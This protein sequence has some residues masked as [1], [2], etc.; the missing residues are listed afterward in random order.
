MLAMPTCTPAD[1]NPSRPSLFVGSLRHRER[2][3]PGYPCM[4]SGGG[5]GASKH[6]S[7][8]GKVYDA[9]GGVASRGEGGCAAA[10]ILQT[11]PIPFQLPA[12][13]LSCGHIVA[14]SCFPHFGC[15]GVCCL[16]FQ[17]EGA[18]HGRPKL[19]KWH[20]KGWRRRQPPERGGAKGH[21]MCTHVVA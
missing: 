14:H 15:L 2:A 13:V 19:Q 18:H 12:C 6:P 16:W 4:R 20:D 17:G 5:G 21:H 11:A 10:G 1:L 8:N 3:S 9:L 7:S